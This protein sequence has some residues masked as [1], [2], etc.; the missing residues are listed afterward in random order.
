MLDSDRH[1]SLLENLLVVPLVGSNCTDPWTDKDL[2]WIHC[3][4]KRIKVA[5]I[6]DPVARFESIIE[7]IIFNDT[8]KLNKYVECLFYI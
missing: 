4:S 1:R 8:W 5:S 2:C 3:H 7:L 6:C